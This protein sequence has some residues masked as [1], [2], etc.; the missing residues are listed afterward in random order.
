MRFSKNVLIFRLGS[1]G[2][3]IVSLPIF[4]KIHKIHPEEDLILLTNQNAS[5]NICSAES[6]LG[7]SGIISKFITYK[8][9]QL[10]IIEVLRVFNLI[11][12]L[13]LEKIYYMPA[14]RT[15]IQ[16]WK[17]YVFFK[18][19]GI[20]KII[21]FPKTRKYRERMIVDDKYFER[22]SQRLV[23]CFSSIGHIDLDDRS[24][25][26]LNFKNE[27]KKKF[28]K[29]TAGFS[30]NE[31]FCINM[32]GKL[33][34]QDWGAQNWK[35]LIIRLYQLLKNKNILLLI[36]GSSQDFKRGEE[37]SEF[38][39]D[40]KL[41]LCGLMNPRESAFAISR[42]KIFVGHDSGPIHLA[43]ATG[44]PCVG[45]Y[46]RG[47]ERIWHPYGENHKILHNSKNIFDITVDNVLE[48]IMD[49]RKEIIT[50]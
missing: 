49:L 1:I 5:E 9:H 32:G 38:W 23:R 8:S 4:N 39:G 35:N 25:W 44:V 6:I 14:K 28:Q 20:K 50:Q 46:G 33:K 42:A 30:F 26:N 16:S 21:G 37:V 22:E 41:N 45:I 31:I 18:L 48:N 7:N 36:V 12:K 15:F 34:A 47:Y 27:E 29:F 10:S 19:C 17:D 2:D 13:N 43:G 11:R 40:Q 3:T 24:Y